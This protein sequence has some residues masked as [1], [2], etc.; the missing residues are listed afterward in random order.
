MTDLV[1]RPAIPD[2]VPGIMALVH[3]LAEYEHKPEAVEATEADLHAALFPPGREP[4][5]FAHVAEL[6]GR[7]VGMAVWYLTFS[8]WTGR[9]GVW[10]EDLFVEPEARRHGAGSALLRALAAVCVERGYPRLEWWVL[11]WNEPALAFYERLGSVPQREWEV[12]RIDG[13]ALSD[14]AR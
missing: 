6:D 4:T 3:A 11:T 2:D 7:V 8:T 1:V 5:T 9:N 14:L 10:L 13:A 12:H